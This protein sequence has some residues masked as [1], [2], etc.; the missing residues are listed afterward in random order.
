[1]RDRE[2]R[3]VFAQDV[4]REHL[5]VRDGGASERPVNTN[6]LR[7]TQQADAPLSGKHNDAPVVSDEYCV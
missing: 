1:M 3:A 2:R 4:K 5:A 7:A 6:V